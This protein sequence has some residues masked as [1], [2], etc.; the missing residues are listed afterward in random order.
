MRRN[1]K[2]SDKDLI[3]VTRNSEQ[4]FKLYLGDVDITFGKL[5]INEITHPTVLENGLETHAITTDWVSPYIAGKVVNG[6][7]SGVRAAVGGNHGT[8]GGSGFATANNLSTSMTVDGS[9]V[10]NSVSTSAKKVVVTVKN[11]ITLK[12]NIDLTT[13]ERSS[14]DAIETVTYTLEKN[15]MAIHVELKALTPLYIYWYMGLQSTNAYFNKAYFTYDIE[16]PSVYEYDRTK[17]DSGT[18]GTS[19]NMTRASMM[20]A[21]DELMHVYTDKDY[22]IGYDYIPDDTVIAYLRENNL[23]L[24]Y[25]L[26]KPGQNLM[27]DEN[28]SHAYRGGYIFSKKEGT[29]AFV[30]RFV[31]DGVKKALV[32]F[33]QVATEQFEYTS[34]EE[35]QNV[36]GNGTSLT[37]S[38]NNAYAKVVI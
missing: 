6:T 18:K 7:P 36:T 3:K 14:V 34:I 15:H 17:L 12:E 1:R 13:G 32:D 11:E 28:Q 24:Y 33:R 20:N 5:G 31:E 27:F 8:V 35:S 2:E 21:S 30:T 9:S 29:N 23:K 25:H 19:P 26:V 16:R 10:N 22:G 38:T 4:D 37:S